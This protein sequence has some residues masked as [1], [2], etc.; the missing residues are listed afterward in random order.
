MQTKI[1][2]LAAVLAIALIAAPA[3]AAAVAQAQD[4]PPVYGIEV[5]EYDRDISQAAGTSAVYLVRARNTGVLELAG[6]RL[7]AEGLPTT[8]FRADAPGAKP[9]RFGDTADMTYRLYIPAGFEGTYVFNIV[10]AASYGAGNTSHSKPVRLEVVAGAGKATTTTAASG[11]IVPGTVARQPAGAALAGSFAEAVGVPFARMRA[12][13][14]YM[15]ATAS[16]VLADSALLRTTAA[17]L[18]VLMLFLAAI[19][20]ALERGARSG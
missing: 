17:A 5:Y 8:I 7:Y 19:Q 16:S 12:G 9:L 11:I 1:S 13:A 4:V 10:A 18:F 6:V 20:K 2:Q 14:E 15:R 3:M